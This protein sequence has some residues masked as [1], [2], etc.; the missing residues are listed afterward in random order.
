M[1]EEQRLKLWKAIPDHLASFGPMTPEDRCIIAKSRLLSA[2]GTCID[3]N[4]PQANIIDM[5]SDLRHLCDRLGLDF[6]ALDRPAYQH[7]LEERHGR[8]TIH[9]ARDPISETPST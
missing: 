1:T 8:P 3:E 5:L 2:V 6:A 7:Y 4:D 9:Q